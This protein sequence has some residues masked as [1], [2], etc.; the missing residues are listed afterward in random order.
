M[1]NRS[2]APARESHSVSGRPISHITKY[3]CRTEREK[4]N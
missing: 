1:S 2:V 4:V 3:L